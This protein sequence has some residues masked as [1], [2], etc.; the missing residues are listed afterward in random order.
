MFSVPC[1][2]MPRSIMG[3]LKSY[4]PQKMCNFISNILSSS[5][6]WV[7]F[8]NL[9]VFGICRGS[10]AAVRCRPVSGE[11]E[12]HR[13]RIPG[14]QKCTTESLAK[15]LRLMQSQHGSRSGGQ[16]QF[17]R[18]TTSLLLPHQNFRS[19]KAP[20]DHYYNLRPWQEPA[21]LPF[22]WCPSRRTHLIGTWKT[23]WTCPAR[24]LSSVFSLAARRKWMRCFN[25]PGSVLNWPNHLMDCH[26][27]G[28]LIGQSGNAAT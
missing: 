16:H 14:I 3:V 28:T 8:H 7:H 1:Q 2:A 21:N 18:H 5:P 13:D 10:G 27:N 26:F 17:H 20:S 23:A 25:A 19:G 9:I 12:T 4:H 15:V 24:L 6:I 22:L 11:D